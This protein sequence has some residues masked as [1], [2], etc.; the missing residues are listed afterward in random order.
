LAS[1]IGW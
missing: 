1:I